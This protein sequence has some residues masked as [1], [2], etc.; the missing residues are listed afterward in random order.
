MENEKIQEFFRQHFRAFLHYLEETEPALT[1]HTGYMKKMHKHILKGTGYFFVKGPNS[2]LPSIDPEYNFRFSKIIQILFTKRT[3]AK[4]NF[5]K[6][7]T[8][9]NRIHAKS[10]F[11]A[12]EWTFT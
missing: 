8:F 5:S 3:I 12:L 2:I 1:N 7:S 6:K 4:P 9:E 10:A 11:P